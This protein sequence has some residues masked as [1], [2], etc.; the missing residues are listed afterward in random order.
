M[1][2]SKILFTEKDMLVAKYCH[3]KSNDCLHYK[4]IITI[5]ESG[6]LPIEMEIIFCGTP[7][8]IASM[9]PEKHTFKAATI[10]D[11]HAKYVK[12]F[13]KYGYIFK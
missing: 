7:P 5:K 4:S 8:S 12:W 6:E 13:R 10:I 3:P 1:K 9:P 11:L 2:K